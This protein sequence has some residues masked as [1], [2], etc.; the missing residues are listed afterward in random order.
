[1]RLSIT[2]TPTRLE[3]EFKIN[4]Y[5][6]VHWL[7]GGGGNYGRRNQKNGGVFFRKRNSVQQSMKGARGEAE[8][9]NRSRN[10]NLDQSYLCWNK[11]SRSS[12]TNE[13]KKVYDQPVSL[14]PLG[15]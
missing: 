13:K 6:N 9:P 10:A 8:A 5:K 12:E 2:T 3:Q 11:D 15:D 7:G 1:M 4:S 14:F